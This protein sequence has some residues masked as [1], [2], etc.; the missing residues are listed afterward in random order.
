MKGSGKLKINNKILL[1]I[2][3]ICSFFFLGNADALSVGRVVYDGKVLLRTGPGYNYSTSGSL[4][5]NDSFLIQSTSTI[6]GSGCNAGWYKFSYNGNIRYICSSHV[7]TAYRTIKVDNKNG[8]NIRK[9][10]GTNYKTYSKI[11]NNKTLSL[12]STTKYKGSGCSAGWYKINYNSN[13]SLYICSSYTDNYISSSNVIVSN[14]SG[15]NLRKSNSSKSSKIASLKY[16]SVL[17]L[18]SKTKYKGSGCSAGYYKV[19][20]NNSTRYV[21][22]SYVYTKSSTYVSNAI[23]GLPIYSNTNATNKTNTISYG[24]PVV[25][26]SSTKYKGKKCS[27]GYYKVNIGKNTRYACSSYVTNT[28]NV[29]STNTKVNIRNG[30]GTNYSKATSFAN[31]AYVILSSATK[32]KGSGCSAGW[33]KINY[34]GSTGYICSSYTELGKTVSSSSSNNISN[35][36]DKKTITKIKTSS[37]Y[38]YTTNNWEYKINENYANIRKSASTSSA[39]VDTL[40]LGTE[41]DVKSS[42]KASSGCSAGWYKITYYNN[43]TGYVCK[44]LVDKKSSITKT[45]SS[46]C[47]TLVKNGFPSSYCPYLSYLHS[48]YPKWVFKAEKTNLSFISAVNGESYKNY[49]QIAEKPYITSTTVREVPNWRTASDGYVAYMLDPRNY[50]NEKNIF[51]FESLSYDKDYHTKSAVRS[52]VDGTYLDTDT[53]AGYFIEAGNKYDVSPLHLASRVKQEGGTNKNY[54]SVSGNSTDSCKIENVYVCSSYVKVNNTKTKAAEFTSSVNLRDGAGTNYSRKTSGVK[55]EDIILSSTTKY[56]GSGCSA[57]WYKIRTI[58]RSLKGIYNYYNIGAYGDNPVLRGLKTA[59]G[60]LDENEGTP[61]NSRKDAIV[62]GAKFIADGYISE[63]QDTMYYQKFN[64]S[65]RAT[66]PKYTHQYMTNILAPAG[67]SLSTYESYSNLGL[68][69]AYVFK[70]PV[71]NNMPVN[72]TTHPQF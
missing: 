10:P 31:G 72:N 63:G 61:W 19:L 34:N 60:C 51:A 33:Y 11:K 12:V 32:Y 43:R 54:D 35:S 40:Y 71:Y 69:K 44:S 1:V 55:G 14:S 62:Y 68:N 18:D 5:Y 25:V 7:S 3:F 48:K 24:T 66:S 64:T 23:S 27:A 26:T 46:Y 58:N 47:N 13:S 52:I 29:T 53:Y 70:I 30:A 41:V 21:C 22:S 65:P 45:N 42:S 16:A 50:L 15:V 8:V 28:S 67:E 56:K 38:Y 37:G 59:A 39:L 4:Y 36:N 2:I 20:Y 57:G 49:T 17:T 9:G 6:K